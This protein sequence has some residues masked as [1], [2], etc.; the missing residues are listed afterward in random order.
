MTMQQ[1]K[2]PIFIVGAPRSGT[3]LLTSFLVSHSGIISGPETQFFNKI[4]LGSKALEQALE[5]ENWPYQA[6]SLM[7]ERLTLSGQS[8]LS[9]YNK[10][11]EQ[12]VN[13][14]KSRSPSISAMLE[15]IVSVK[16]VELGEQRWLE[17]TPNHLKHIAD[18]K[19]HFP[20]AK[21][22]LIH[23]DFRDSAS[24]I[25]KLPWASS[26][27][28]ENAAL[29]HSWYKSAEKELSIDDV[30]VQS[31]EKLVMNPE[32]ELRKLFAYIEEPFDNKILE[33]KG[34]EAVT[35]ENEP[36][37]QDVYQKIDN[38]NLTK[39]RGK[40]Q[41]D[42]LVQTEGILGNLLGKYGY[43]ATT[44]KTFKPL[45][46]KR[47]KKQ[48]FEGLDSFASVLNDYGFKLS[49]VN[50]IED[51]LLFVEDGLVFRAC[52]AAIK[53]KLTRNDPLYLLGKKNTLLSLLG[54]YL[55]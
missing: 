33:R 41:G 37:K 17:K 12:V 22:I 50:D 3:T 51:T 13:F 48:K 47:L 28:A 52:I 38:Q 16:S 54:R 11:R 5:N 55:N 29:I 25:P 15:S 26:S 36:W 44:T 53:L 45:R 23:R 4:G 21:I 46:L 35:T 19:A 31:Y 20:V 14:L 8:V 10:N 2:S 24:S 1:G 32:G 34:A 42:I 27:I 7:E 43:E 18:I 40:L 9:L 39:W 30:Y 6:V 49:Y